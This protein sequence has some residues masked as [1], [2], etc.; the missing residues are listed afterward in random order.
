MLYRQSQQRNEIF[1]LAHLSD[2]HLTSLAHVK[3]RAL[4]NKRALGYLSWRF[5]RRHEHMPAILDALRHDLDGLAPDHIVIT[6]DLTHI[7]LPDECQQVRRWLETLGSPTEV[8]VVPGNHD[9]YIRGRWEDTLALW[10]PYM[11]S[12]PGLNIGE[13][14]E[15]GRSFFP[16]VRMRG[17]AV[18]IGVNS[19]RPSA[20]FF[21]TGGLGTAQIERLGAVLDRTRRQ[22]RFRI[23]LIHHPPVTAMVAWRKRLTDGA[24]LRALLARYGVEMVLHGHAHRSSVA[25]LSTGSGAIPLIGVPSASSRRVQARRCGGY[26]IYEVRP[27]PG[28]WEISVSMRGYSPDGR[29][30]VAEEQRALS[31]FGSTVNSTDATIHPYGYTAQDGQRT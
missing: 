6:G 11:V 5:R 1:R 16:S 4:L 10:T 28:G 9:A 13:Q 30:F 19:A 7:G 21:A 24:T 27:S 26:H 17:P 29:C 18:L 22:G 25:Y 12:D 31:V 20:P 14:Q 2:L 15:P 23:L 3:I 8:T